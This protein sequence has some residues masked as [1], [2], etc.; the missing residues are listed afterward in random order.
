M[1]LCS[2]QP[3]AEDWA[4]GL[5]VQLSLGGPQ[6]EGKHLAVSVSDRKLLLLSH[7]PQLQPRP[8]LWVAAPPGEPPGG[9][10]PSGRDKEAWLRSHGR[11]E[12]LE[13][14]GPPSPWEYDARCGGVGMKAGGAL[15]CIAHHLTV[16]C[17]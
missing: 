3:R 13:A 8:K 9:D 2:P 16:T 6:E 12:P 1:R 10:S 17:F 4:S 14:S 11:A 15:T 5:W 7:S